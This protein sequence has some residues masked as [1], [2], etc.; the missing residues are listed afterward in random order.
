MEQP[1]LNF[2][3]PDELPPFERDTDTTGLLEFTPEALR[4]VCLLRRILFI[5]CSYDCC[6]VV[7]RSPSRSRAV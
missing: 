5:F 1:Q 7:I 6:V 3:L 4:G 2:S